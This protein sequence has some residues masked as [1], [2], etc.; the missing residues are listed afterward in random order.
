LENPE[1]NDFAFAEEVTIAGANTKRPD[2]VL[3][4]NGIAPV[5]ALCEPV[6]PPRDSLAYQHFFCGSDT[7]D[8]EALKDNEPKRVTLYKLVGSL[9]RAYA[10]IANE[11][12]DAGYTPPR[13]RRSGLTS[14][15]M[16]SCGR[17]SSWPAAITL[18]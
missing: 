18:T 1:N 2:I 10:D 12:A 17:K 3:Y 6:D 9:L 7:S 8:P 11:M 5:K 16:R 14:S 15:Y 4:V 13:H